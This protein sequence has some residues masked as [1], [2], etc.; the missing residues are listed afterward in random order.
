MIKFEGKTISEIYAEPTCEVPKHVLRAR[1]TAGEPLE[2]A[3]K[4]RNFV[5]CGKKYISLWELS[6]ETLPLLTYQQLVYRICVQK[7]SVDKAVHCVLLWVEGKRQTG[8][9]ARRSRTQVVPTCA[10]SRMNPS[11]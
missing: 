6:K 5:C 10:L 8:R 4:L 2:K 3:K 11:S 9:R 7:M 1:L